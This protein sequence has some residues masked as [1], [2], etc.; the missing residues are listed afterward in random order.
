MRTKDTIEEEVDAIRDRIYARTKDM[1]MEERC[2]YYNSRARETFKRMG[3][4]F[5][6]GQTVLNISPRPN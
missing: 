6:P 3:W 2:E 5:R 1:T 4:V